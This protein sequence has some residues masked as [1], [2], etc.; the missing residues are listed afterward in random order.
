MS[1]SQY[2]ED[3]LIDSFFKEKVGYFLDIGAA[4]GK[5]NS[6]TRNLF[7]KGWSGLL[8]EPCRHFF[9]PLKILYENEKNVKIFNGAVSEFSGKTDFYVY[10]DGGDSQISTISLAQKESIENSSWFSG[11]FT[12][13]YEVSVKTPSD[14]IKDY[15]IPSIVQFVDIDAEG[16]DM[17]ILKVWPWQIIEVE[18][19]CIEPSM[20]KDNLKSF[21]EAKGY[22]NNMSTGGNMFF[23]RKT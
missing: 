12:E 21:M 2:G 8:V 5:T 18:L 7:L 14:L 22:V 6:N 17:Q 23:A 10:E 9:E 13:S 19:F 4:D 11:R 3:R 16:S 15:D 20:G 1:Y